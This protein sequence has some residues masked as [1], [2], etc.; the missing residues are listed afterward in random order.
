MKEYQEKVKLIVEE[1]TKLFPEEFKAFKK[2]HTV[3]L[4]MNKDKFASTGMDTITRKLYEIPETLFAML[5]T[6]LSDEDWAEFTTK[7]G[8]RWFAKSFKPFRAS[9]KV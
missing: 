3:E 5:K 1:Y 2:A 9:E 7:Q 4:E 8:S 6:R